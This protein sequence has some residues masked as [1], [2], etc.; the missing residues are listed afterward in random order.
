[1]K[2][3]SP[4]VIIRNAT[5]MTLAVTAQKFLSFVYF[6]LI[7]RSLPV[8]QTGLYIYALSV[9][10]AASFLFDMGFSPVIT[11][12]SAKDAERGR[13]LLTIAVGVKLIVSAIVLS[14]VGIWTQTLSDGVLR[15]MI[16]LAFLAVAFDSIQ[17][18]CYGYLRS[19][20]LLGYEAVA[21]VLG[22]I[23]T[24]TIGGLVLYARAPLWVLAAA[25]SLTSLLHCLY[26]VV[27]IRRCCGWWV[28]PELDG[29]LARAIIQQSWPFL[30]AAIGVKIMSSVD[31]IV[32]KH[33]LGDAMTGLYSVPFK[34]TYSWQFIPLALI[35]ALYP[36]MSSYHVSDQ[37]LLKRSVQEG[38][39]ALLLVA[40]PL[41][42]GIAI[43][44]PYFIPLVYGQQYEQSIVPT[45]IL[46]FALV[47]VFAQYPLGS[48]LN[49]SNRQ[50]TYASFV[51]IA[52]V[53]NVVASL[54]LIPLWGL[55][56]AA[57][58]GVGANVLLFILSYWKAH[59]QIGLPWSWLSRIL[60]Q[61]LV[62]AFV[63]A[64]IT[65]VLSSMI[66]LLPVVIVA[67][68]VYGVGVFVTGAVGKHEVEIVRG[69]LKKRAVEV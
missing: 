55:V 10:F 9:A 59:Q 22:Q 1:M 42:F 21:M 40:I 53:F 5:A 19:R 54:T 67:M 16:R 47:A 28:W 39:R 31:T 62:P 13:R 49:S 18:S 56:G 66:S 36:A 60:A 63:M 25:L 37:A 68:L 57:T 3:H 30:L 2:T 44:S 65:V 52:M 26:S 45:Q 48:L 29:S 69:L 11:R 15:L 32:I 33:V 24:M 4:H 51:I 43:L 8:E 12:E 20:Q 23:L 50:L 38:L 61:L 14:V 34:L 17:I 35:S 41:S 27:L 64:A 7:A 6:T 46:V 58:S